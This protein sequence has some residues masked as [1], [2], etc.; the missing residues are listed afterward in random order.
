MSSGITT[1]SLA[2]FLRA[3][4]A[5][6]GLIVEPGRFL[7]E[8]STMSG[9][10]RSRPSELLETR[11]LPDI[12][13]L[14]ETLFALAPLLMA[15]RRDGAFIDIWKLS[16]VGRNEV[17]NCAVLAWIFDAHES[18]GKGNAVFAAFLRRLWSKH[19]K[20]SLPIDPG[21]RYAVF[22]ELNPD[23]DEANRVDLVID[24]PDFVIFIEA[25]IDAV[26]GNN[27]LARYLSLAKN[28]A[29]R[30]GK[31]CYVV[32][33]LCPAANRGLSIPKTDHLV[34]ATWR[35]VAAAIGEVERSTGDI[36][37]FAA[38]LLGQFKSHIRKF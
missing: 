38:R 24:G 9:S 20:V 15:A 33:F 31:P 1:S 25:K 16:R 29:S 23:G 22:R 37:S 35:D 30:A 4:R 11:N 27:Q 17:R 32:I 14:S 2:C 19:P 10:S 18:H 6:V 36:E 13:R 28:R 12:V 26:E 5:E 21:E 8:L 3:W 7:P 34:V